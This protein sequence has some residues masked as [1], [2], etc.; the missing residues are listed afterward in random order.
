[1]RSLHILYCHRLSALSIWVASPQIN[2]AS[3]I[4]GCKMFMS[5]WNVLNLYKVADNTYVFAWKTSFAQSQSWWYHLEYQLHKPS[6]LCPALLWT[7]DRIQLAWHSSKLQSIIAQIMF[8]LIK[9]AIR[10]C[11]IH[12]QII[13]HL[14]LHTLYGTSHTQLE[15]T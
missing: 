13:D 6:L 3:C 2:S 8:Q 9:L 15:R 5:S 11:F 1:M 4:K 7:C 14:T 10:Y 12:S